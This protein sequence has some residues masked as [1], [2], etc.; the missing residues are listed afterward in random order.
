MHRNNF[1]TRVSISFHD[2]SSVIC[3]KLQPSASVNR[4]PRSHPS[5][6]FVY[7]RLIVLNQSV[8]RCCFVHDTTRRISV[9]RRHVLSP[10]GQS[11]TRCVTCPICAKSTELFLP[12]INWF[13][14]EIIEIFMYLM[15][16]LISRETFC[17]SFIL[18][19]SLKILSRF[20][21]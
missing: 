4:H 1:I 11:V 9:Y 8:F 14:F 2:C 20:L 18:W 12:R 5:H 3:I 10:T 13:S 7:A 6:A 16:I 21:Q 15:Q 19:R 17:V